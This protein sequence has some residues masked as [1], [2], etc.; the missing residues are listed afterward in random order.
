MTG[1]R[2]LPTRASFRFWWPMTVRWGDMDAM[3][4]VNNIMLFQYMES[5]RV[6]FFETMGW[7]GWK[8]TSARQGPVVVSQ[9]LNYRKQLLYP[10]ELEVGLRC[11]EIRGRSFVL[12]C[13][14][15]WKDSDDL[16]GDGAT[17]LVWL[18]YGSGKAVDLP[19][20]IRGALADK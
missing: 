15:F 9:T 5:A 3:G 2:T 14:I 12:Q 4:H 13:G 17:V 10:A 18:D 16:A 11:A 6:G 1:H 20:D 8:E 7:K 19:L